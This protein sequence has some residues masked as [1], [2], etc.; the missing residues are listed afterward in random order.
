MLA[1]MVAA[2]APL[3]AQGPAQSPQD[4]GFAAH[5]FA[6]ELVMQHQRAVGL[7]K[8][9]RDRITEAVRS[10][11]HQVLDLQWRMQDEA[12]KLSDLVQG[13][14][15]DQRAVLAQAD[16]VFEVEAQITRAHLGLLA[17]IKN[18]LT[19]DQQAQLRRLRAQAGSSRP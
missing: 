16:R 13:D 2:A 11:Q 3:A 12:Q 5:L 7:S 9:Q 15:V 4:P 18:A 17:Q 19:P 6:P 1:A 10:L 14:R 8:E